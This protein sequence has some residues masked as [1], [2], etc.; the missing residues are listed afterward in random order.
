MTPRAPVTDCASPI[1]DAIH[2]AEDVIG[3]TV[4]VKHGGIDR[5]DS[6]PVSPIGRDAVVRNR[7]AEQRHR[8]EDVC[9]S[10]S[11]SSRSVAPVTRAPSEWANRWTGRPSSSAH[12]D[13]QSASG[14]TL[15]SAVCFAGPQSTFDAHE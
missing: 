12:A 11:A 7:A 6:R 3:P 15:A 13:N 1:R 2:P 10:R 8:G 4:E 14:A 5:R 9:R